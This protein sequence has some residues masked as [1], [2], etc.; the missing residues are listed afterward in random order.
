MDGREKAAQLRSAQ[1]RDVG[2]A[3][4]GGEDRRIAQVG[5]A[6][7]QRPRPQML[8]NAA[9][10]AALTAA[11]AGGAIAGAAALRI[12]RLPYAGGR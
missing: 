4:E 3:G 9:R 11:M 1:P 2:V 12:R 8:A 7:M 6:G 10:C 5:G